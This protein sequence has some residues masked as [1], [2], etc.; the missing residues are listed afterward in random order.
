[1]SFGPARPGLRHGGVDG[2]R[3]RRR[4]GGRRQVA[5]EKRDLGLF[6]IGQILP[7]A[8]AELFDRIAP[9]LDER[10]DDLQRL[11]VVERAALLDLPVHERRL[12]HAQ[13][14][15]RR[16]ILLPHRVGDVFGDLFEQ[17]GH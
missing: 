5:F 3:D 6:P 7:A 1:M 14:R 9:L 16:L 11:G 4:V 8:G 10:L 12:Q 13:R 15:E 2:L 17:C